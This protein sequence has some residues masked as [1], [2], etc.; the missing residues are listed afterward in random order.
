MEKETQAILSF[1]A[2]IEL[3]FE[4]TTLQ[5]KTF[6]PGLKLD[7]GKLLIDLEQLKYPG[8]ILHEAGHIAVCEPTERDLLS[9]NVYQSGRNKDWMHGEEMAAIA[10]SVA[11]IKSLG[12]PL[13]VVFH[14]DGYKGQSEAL[15]EM[16]SNNEGFGFP[17]LGAWDMLDAERGFPYMQS[18]IRT[19]SWA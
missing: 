18:W 17:L 7:Q 11:A 10:W 2:D 16:F 8:D 12:L 4:L 13:N 9:D 5:G 14:P 15:I 19:L 3:P 1:L 6:L